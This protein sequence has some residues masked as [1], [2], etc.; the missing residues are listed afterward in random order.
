MY[1]LIVWVTLLAVGLNISA[2]MLIALERFILVA[3]WKF[4]RKHVTLRRQVG[5]CM[6]FSVYFLLFAT[7][8]V[9]LL[10]DSEFKHGVLLIRSKHTAVSTALFVPTYTLITFTLVCCYLQ[11]CFFIWKQRK[12]LVLRQ[13]SSNQGDFQ[14]EKKTTVLITIILTVYLAGTLP[15]FVYAMLTE[16]NPKYLAID[17]LELFRLLWC[18][19]TLVDIFICAWKVPQFQEGYCKILCGLLKSRSI[20]V[21]PQPHVHS[22]RNSL[23]LEP[24]REFDSSG[25][26]MNNLVAVIESGRIPSSSEG[27]DKRTYNR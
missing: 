23:P 10:I 22:S 15:P 13:N 3:S 9:M 2:M 6:A 7:T 8:Q 20:Q 18:A 12:T 1:D 5:L 4:H 27:H 24:R 16:N 11:I 19:T 26:E 21:V 17:L 25:F 14:K